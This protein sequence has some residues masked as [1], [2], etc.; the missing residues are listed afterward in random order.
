MIKGA[1]HT[2]TFYAES[3]S[4]DGYGQKA[5]RTAQLS[6]VPVRL[7]D[8]QAR[9]V[10]L[11]RQIDATVTHVLEIQGLNADAIK[12][13]WQCVIGTREYG[14]IGTTQ[15]DYGRPRILVAAVERVPKA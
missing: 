9:E 2:A 4:E 15:P 14:V 10:Q 13:F 8:G 5:A 7:I 11:A 3:G 12:P 1:R 6:N